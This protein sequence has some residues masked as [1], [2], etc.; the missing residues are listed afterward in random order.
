MYQENFRIDQQKLL[1]FKEMAKT[2]ARGTTSE[3]IILP[4]GIRHHYKSDDG[5]TFA[6]GSLV[7]Q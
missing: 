2:E 7:A 6:M 1:V 5:K 4:L 3:D